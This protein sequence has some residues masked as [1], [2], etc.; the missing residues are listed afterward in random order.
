YNPLNQILP[1][2]LSAHPPYIPPQNQPTNQI[3]HIH[4]H[5]IIQ[6]LLSNYL[7]HSNN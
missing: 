3:P 4:P 6:E 7:K 5:L 2:L 1:Y